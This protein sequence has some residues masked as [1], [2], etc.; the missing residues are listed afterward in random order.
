M[1]S[2]VNREDVDQILSIGLFGQILCVYNMNGRMEIYIIHTGVY[3][4]LRKYCTT[5]VRWYCKFLLY[6]YL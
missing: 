4:R 1:K 3:S 6:Q 5:W 2:T